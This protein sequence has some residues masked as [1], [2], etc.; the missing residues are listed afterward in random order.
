MQ[1]KE[2]W[3]ACLYCITMPEENQ[4]WKSNTSELVAWAASKNGDLLRT[5]THQATQSGM[6]TKN[7]LFKSANLMKWWKSERG[8]LLMNNHAVCSQI[9]RT[10][11]LLMTMIWTLTPSQNQICR[12]DPDHSCKGEWSSAKDAGPILKR[13]NT[14]QQQTFFNM[15]NIHVFNI[16]KHLFSWERNTQKFYAPSK[17]QGTLSQLNRCSTYLKSW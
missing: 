6:L 2:S 10:D 16:T 15:G 8:D 1:R 3:L 9:T 17:T 4:I 7:G 14:R 5:L 13:C 11:L 12:Q